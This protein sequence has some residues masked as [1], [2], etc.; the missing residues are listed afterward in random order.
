MADLLV[1]LG[2]QNAINLDGGGSATAVQN[3]TVVNFPSDECPA[4]YHGVT[5]SCERAVTSVTCF[6]R[7]TVQ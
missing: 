5:T 7:S 1:D 3:G 6:H 4:A 2:V